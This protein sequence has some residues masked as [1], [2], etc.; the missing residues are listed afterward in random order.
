MP[1]FDQG[2]QR[3][4]GRLGRPAWRWLTI[5]RQGL[6][7]HQKNRLLRV[8]LM[9]AWLPAIA[10]AT[11]VSV[12]GLVEQRAISVLQFVSGFL[13]PPMIAEPRAFRH[14]VWTISYTYFFQTQLF[15]IMLLAVL[16]GPGLVSRD[17]RFNSFPL[18]FSRPVRRFDYFLG[19]LG[20]IGGLVAAVAVVPAV[21]AY[22][23]GIGFSLD[24]TVVRDTYPLLLASI[25]YGLLIVV[26]VGTL[27]LA[28]S[29]LSRRSVYVGITWCG[30]W[31]ISGAV[32]GVL[33]GVHRESMQREMARQSW[34]TRVPSDMDKLQASLEQKFADEARRDWRPLFSLTNSLAR[35][36][37]ELL[38][39]D[40]AWVEIGR[41][42]PST[43]PPGGGVLSG[44]LPVPPANE[45][46]LADQLAMQ[47]PW[48][49]SAGVVGGLVVLSLLVLTTRVKSLDR[50]R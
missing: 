44:F 47:Y 20:V 45:R 10:L 3:W 1:I 2:Y 16:V 19:K 6:R 46:R 14:A 41:A 42:I 7:A 38:E 48:Q 26:T 15:I 4:Q 11:V 43:R 24:W 5:T 33:E 30:L 29:S 22:L 37:Q 21:V 34:A 9:M 28:L 8:L 17:L 50:L 35:L 13:P 12:W 27:M 31:L 49:W 25:L 18:Y 32:S 36:G 23:L 40:R 39:T